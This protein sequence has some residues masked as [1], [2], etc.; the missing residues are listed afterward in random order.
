[1]NIIIEK[2]KMYMFTEKFYTVRLSFSFAY[3][4]EMT[5]TFVVKPRKRVFFQVF[6]SRTFPKT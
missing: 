5:E 2:K 6:I 1:M 3:V 4:V